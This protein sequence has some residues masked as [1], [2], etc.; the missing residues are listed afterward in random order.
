VGD[1]ELSS[2][3]HDAR[4]YMGPYDVQILSATPVHHLHTVATLRANQESPKQ[5]RVD[6]KLISMS[7]AYDD[8]IFLSQ[9][10]KALEWL[11][12]V[13]QRRQWQV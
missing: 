11:L 9:M 12:V 3:C 5:T 8:H 4:F 6:H 7:E 1:G 10:V 13:I 2:V